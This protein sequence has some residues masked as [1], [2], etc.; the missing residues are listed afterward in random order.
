[1]RHVLIT[2]GAG[3]IGCL[4]ARRLLEKGDQVTVFDNLHP[5]VHT[6][7]GRPARL[8]AGANLQVGDVTHEDNWRS[9]LAL[10][11]PDVVVHLAAE[12]GTGQSLTAASR[13]AAV[14]ALGTAR[15]LDAFSRLGWTPSRMLLSSSRAVYGDGAWRDREGRVF[16]PAGR[17]HADL[18]AGRWDCMAPGNHPGVPLA[19]DARTTQCNPTSVYGATKLVQEHMMAA[20]CR[21]FGSQLS[22]LRLQNVYGAGQAVGNPYTGVLTFFARQVR[23]GQQVEVY[24]D[25]QIIRDFVHVD[26]VVSAMCLALDSQDSDPTPI[27]IGCGQSTTIAEVAALMSRASGIPC[28]VSG[29]F[30]D[31]DVRSAWANIDAARARIGYA[32]AVPLETGL[33]RLIDSVPPLSA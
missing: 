31:G 22:V 32:P 27:D 21:A 20:W 2:G 19:N 30:R 8:P 33:Q 9:L 12:T 25:G 17:S 18:E 28:R 26:D 11:R 23:S 5:Q 14:N 15:M 29:R 24:E 6:E 1:M 4:L 7:Q 13:H 16:Y 3:F 10:G